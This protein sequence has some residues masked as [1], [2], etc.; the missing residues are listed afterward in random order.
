[1]IHKQGLCNRK[2][3]FFTTSTAIRQR[4]SVQQIHVTTQYRS[5]TLLLPYS[6]TAYNPEQIPSTS[7]SQYI[8]LK[9]LHVVTSLLQQHSEHVVSTSG[10]SCLA[11]LTINY[12]L[13]RKYH[14]N[15][16]C[17]MPVIRRLNY[18]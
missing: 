17:V 7:S 16:C 15:H 6:Y 4:I 3:A 1:M 11:G 9:S 13:G 2:I 10:T 5:S 8:N 12:W 18:I 14:D